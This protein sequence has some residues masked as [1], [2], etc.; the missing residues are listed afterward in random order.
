MFL[1]SIIFCILASHAQPGDTEKGS[2]EYKEKVGKE[3]VGVLQQLVKENTRK[4]EISRNHLCS[5]PS[6][7]TELEEGSCL[8]SGACRLYGQ[9]FMYQGGCTRR[10]WGGG[11]KMLVT[12]R[13]MVQ[14][15]CTKSGHCW[16]GYHIKLLSKD[17]K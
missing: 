13:S 17:C 14:G 7:A 8:V 1:W 16:T 4:K 9:D 2:K 5:F 6:Y 11:C 3:I 12:R 10:R 15:R